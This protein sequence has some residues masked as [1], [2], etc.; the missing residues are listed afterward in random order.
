MDTTTALRGRILAATTRAELDE[1]AI[2]MAGLG[3][4]DMEGPEDDTTTVAEARAILLSDLEDDDATTD[5]AAGGDT[6][7]HSATAGS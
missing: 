2:E 3:C 1:I 6:F 7:E 4:V 5:G